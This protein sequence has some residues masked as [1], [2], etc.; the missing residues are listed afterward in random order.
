VGR[1]DP[2]AEIVL[3]DALLREVLTQG[4]YHRVA[5][6]LADEHVVVGGTVTVRHIAI[7]A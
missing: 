6:R 1:L 4:R 5:L 7:L 3:A 2:A